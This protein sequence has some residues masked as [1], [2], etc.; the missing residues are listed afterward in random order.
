ML[1]SV[2]HKR[3]HKVGGGY[4][5]VVWRHVSAEDDQRCSWGSP[6]KPVG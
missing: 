1:C 6:R 5:Y 4:P 3:V 2:C